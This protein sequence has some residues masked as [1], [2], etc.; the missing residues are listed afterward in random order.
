MMTLTFSMPDF[1][2]AMSLN[3]PAFAIC[4][5]CSAN[6]LSGP[7]SFSIASRSFSK[8]GPA[9]SSTFQSEG[10]EIAIPEV[11]ASVQPAILDADMDGFGAEL[12]VASL[13]HPSNTTARRDKQK[14]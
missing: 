7:L 1:E 13:L 3:V 5:A 12:V 9:G 10:K 6:L 11:L 14:A 2:I 8:S 4:R